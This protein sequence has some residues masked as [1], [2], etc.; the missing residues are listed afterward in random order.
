MNF[1]RG[2]SRV[3]SLFSVFASIASDDRRDTHTLSIQ[4]VKFLWSIAKKGE[5]KRQRERKTILK[6]FGWRADGFRLERGEDGG[7]DLLKPAAQ[8]AVLRSQ[9]K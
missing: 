8:L 6:T 3:S 4:V 9:Y 1:G 2:V 7:V 5:R